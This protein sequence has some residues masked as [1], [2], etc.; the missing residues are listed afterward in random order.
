M[1]SKKNKN[2][3]KKRMGQE[4]DK[5]NKKNEMCK[6]QKCGHRTRRNKLRNNKQASTHKQAIQKMEQ[7][8]S[9]PD[10]LPPFLSLPFYPSL[11]LT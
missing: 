9:Y 11:P 1:K 4:I 2:K 6:P 8:Q 3:N 5:M 10:S 7:T